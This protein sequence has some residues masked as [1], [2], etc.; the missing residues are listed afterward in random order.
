MLA[1]V[2][3]GVQRFILVYLPTLSHVQILARARN[4]LSNAMVVGGRGS[5]PGSRWVDVGVRRTNTTV[6]GWSKRKRSYNCNV[7]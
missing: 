4:A 1:E 2:K 5:L 7:C 3:N 6:T